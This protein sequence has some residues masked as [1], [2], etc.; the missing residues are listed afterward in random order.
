MHAKLC[1]AAKLNAGAPKGAFMKAIWKLALLVSLFTAVSQG[2]A[3][4]T[5]NSFTSSFTPKTNY[6]ESI[7]MVVGSGSNTY[8]QFSFPGLPSGLNG[9]NVSAADLV[10]YVDDM[11][12]AGTMDVYAVSGSWSASA[13][14]YDNA[15]ALGSKILSAVAVG[16]TG[17]ISLNITSTVQAWLN[18]TL[19]N[20][21]IA[22]MPTSGS[23]ILVAI[24]SIDN[25]L[26]SHPAQLNL[27][28]VSAGQ[29]GPQGPAG[30]TG[31]TGVTGSQGPQGATG[32]TGATGP[33][34]PAGPVGPSGPSATI[35]VGTVNTGTPGSQASVTNTG[36]PNAAV[37]SFTI[38]QGL[39]GTG[40]APSSV[41]SAFLP[42]PM[43][44]AYTAASLVPDSAITVTRISAALKTAPDSSCPASAVRVTNGTAG[45]DVLFTAGESVQ[46]T[47][48]IQIPTAAGSTLQV[49][50]ENPA[51]CPRT[52]PADTNVLVEYR[53]EQSG[54]TQTCAQSGLTCN[55]IC[56]ES[57]TDSNNCGACGNSCTATNGGPTCCSNACTN[58]NTDNKN[59]GAC[60]VTCTGQTT[61]SNGGCCSSG[62]TY[63]AAGSSQGVCTNLS[64]DANNCG[65]CGNTCQD[66]CSS[67]VCVSGNNGPCGS[68]VSCASGLVCCGGTCTAPDEC[69][70]E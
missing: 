26:T 32:A 33:Q 28:L 67:G 37:L 60:G 48:P 40:T 11:A 58:M 41:M 4:L 44:Q 63:C 68:G 62:Q 6:S 65:S 56:E 13:I 46:D 22:L 30:P 69:A 52:N 36:T 34:G 54:D 5:G 38:P 2:Q 3:V 21:G 64:S 31:A 42:G 12:K 50:V 59:C 45:Q 7:A 24:D 25:I 61:C 55:G 47:G 9:S 20:N 57:V 18:G 43:T 53:A 15:P 29:Q 23:S 14:T 27:V 19:A 16:T 49:K 39:N 35:Q 51:N 1:G 10:V 66:T 8:L 70:S 17:Y